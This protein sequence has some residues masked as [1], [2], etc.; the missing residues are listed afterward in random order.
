MTGYFEIYDIGDNT[1]TINS[2]EDAEFAGLMSKYND[3][4]ITIQGVGEVDLELDA[5]AWADTGVDQ[6]IDGVTYNVYH[7]NGADTSSD[8]WIQDSVQVV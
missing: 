3:H 4:A 8:L 6:V 5:A 1:L 2:L 7:Y